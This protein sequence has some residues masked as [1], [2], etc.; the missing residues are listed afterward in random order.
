MDILDFDADEAV[1]AA[2]YLI[3]NEAI[4]MFDDAA[5]ACECGDRAAERRARDRHFHLVLAHSRLLRD[6]LILQ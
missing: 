2:S 4:S 3:A 6:K 1:G 5:T